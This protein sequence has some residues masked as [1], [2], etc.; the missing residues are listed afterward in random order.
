MI[1]TALRI[2][3]EVI[4]YLVNDIKTLTF[5]NPTSTKVS[6]GLDVSYKTTGK[7]QKTSLYDKIAKSL[8]SFLFKIGRNQ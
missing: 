2:I 7:L 8:Q 3:F 4:P 1:S 5:S 6:V